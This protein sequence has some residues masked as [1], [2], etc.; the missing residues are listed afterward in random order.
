MPAHA[1]QSKSRTSRGS[2]PNTTAGGVAAKK[3]WVYDGQPMLTS[4]QSKQNTNTHTWRT[5]QQPSKTNVQ[6]RGRLGRAAHY[7]TPQVD[8]LAFVAP[9]SPL[10][11]HSI[12]ARKRILGHKPT[13]QALAL[14]W[15][16]ALITARGPTVAKWRWLM[17][18][19][20]DRQVA[21]AAV[22]DGVEDGVVSWLDMDMSLERTE[23]EE[24]GEEKVRQRRRQTEEKRGRKKGRGCFSVFLPCLWRTYVS[25]C[26]RPG[27]YWWT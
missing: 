11:E 14:T 2:N 7:K 16:P 15:A 22:M 4:N 6:T 1:F 27:R 17:D 13:P 3:Q 5:P 24:R 20:M 25:W 21:E 10:E 8:C 18:G 26:W 9:P 12:Y 19:R 23:Q